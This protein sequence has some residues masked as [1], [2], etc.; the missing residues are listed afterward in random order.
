MLGIGVA[1]LAGGFALKQAQA[2]AQ[3]SDGTARPANGQTD[4][5]SQWERS[6]S[7]GPIEVKPRAPG[8]PGKDYAPVATPDGATLPFKIVGGVKVFHLVAEEVTHAFD[9]GLRAKCWGFNGRVNGTL[10]EAVEGERVRIYVT[11]RLPVATSVHWHGVYLPNGMDGVGGLT[12]P[13]IKPGETVKYEWTLRQHGTQMF[14]SHHDEMTQMGMGMIGMFI[15][16]PRNP[17]PVYRVERDFALLLSEWTIEAGTARPNTL[18]M[19]DFNVLTINGKVF[20]STAPLVC[21]TGDKVRIR[22][23]NLGAMDRHPMHIHGYHF[24]ITATDGGD[25][26][27][28]AQWPEST[29]VVGV[30]QT[31]NIEFIAD[32]PGDWAFHCHMTHHV[33]NQ[34]GHQFPNMVGVKPEGLDDKLRPLLPA[35][36]TMGQTGMD[37]GQMAESMPMPRNTIAMKGVAGPFGEYISMGG[38]MTVIKVRDRLNSYDADLG[39]YQHPTGT[40]AMKAT[41]WELREDGIELGGN[42]ADGEGKD[43]QKGQ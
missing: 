23:G 30:G 20:P 24:R 4:R 9:P 18:K 3:N 38:M 7:G 16:H 10:I 39:W 26:P 11:N 19:N 6:Y 17:A 15:I 36:M 43:A 32:A 31:R 21:R 42:V 13:S 27:L 22:L 34:M 41:D 37:M 28:S 2:D 8:L 40:V 35:Y 14:H 25:I 12:Q 29:V 5:R 1:G 33:M